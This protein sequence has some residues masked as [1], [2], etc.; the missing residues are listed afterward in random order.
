MEWAHAIAPGANILLVEA[1]SDNSPDLLTGVHYA[2]AQPGVSVVSMS[3]ATG[4]FT[5]ET[6]LD[7]Y[8]T[9]PTGHNGVTFVAA[10]GDDGSA[11]ANW[12]S[13]SA[14]VLAVGGTQLST[15]AA[16]DYLG[17]TGWSGSGGGLSTGVSQPAYQEGIVTQSSTARAVPDVAYDASGTRPS[18]STTPPSTAAGSRPTAPAPGRRSGPP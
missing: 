2:A 4:E 10:S 14:D 1:A 5:G 8:F 7:D 3:W 12:P 9:T 15:D 11:R 16:G 17:E 13:V 6:S 18:R